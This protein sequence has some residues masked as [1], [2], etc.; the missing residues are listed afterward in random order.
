MNNW[1]KVKLSDIIEFNPRET[2]SKGAIAKKIAMENLEPFTRDIPEFEYLEFRGGTKFRNGD[3]LMARITP[4]LENGKTSKVNLLDEDEVGFGS[5]EFIVVRSK[6]NISDENFVYYLMIAP[7]IREVAIKSMVGTSGRQRVQLDVVKNHE[8]L[9][10]P[11]KEQIRIGKTLKALDDK[12]E[13]NKKINHHLEEILQA[14]LEKQ[15][16]SISIKSKIIDLNLTVSD[17]V[18][19]GS[20][21][22]LKDNVKLVEKTDYALFLRNID[23]KNHLNGERRYVTE[24]SYEFLKKSRLYGHEVIISNVADVGSVHRVPKM[25]MPMVAGNNV[26]F[27]QSENSLLTDYL[28]VY[29]NSRLGQHD[30]MSITSGSAQQ[31]FNKTDFRNLEIPILSDD[32]IK[33]KISSILHYIDNIH[34]EIACLMKIRATLLPKLLSG[35][36][37]VN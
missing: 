22:S 14:N 32:I 27:L 34:E 2:L 1:K 11:L 29:F 8:I 3:T 16:E 20:F 12:I 21:K 7:N 19:N 10:P 9:C 25:N 13:N 6:E 31:K 4:S 17:H 5:T 15:L 36:I 37:S 30:I 33:K 23:L 18:A 28:Y 35:E 26:V 24:S